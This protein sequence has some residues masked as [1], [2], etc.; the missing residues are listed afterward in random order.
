[1]DGVT[2]FFGDEMGGSKT[3]QVATLRISA[4]QKGLCIAALSIA[5]IVFAL[6]SAD[7]ILGLLGMYQLAPF[8]FANMIIDIVFVVCSIILALMSWFTLREQV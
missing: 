3:P 8:K 5:V 6:F 2:V 7:L 1:L 4:V